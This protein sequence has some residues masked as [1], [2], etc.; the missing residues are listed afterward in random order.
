MQ[1][2]LKKKA[3][4]GP[5]PAEERYNRALHAANCAATGD[6]GS[7]IKAIAESNLNYQDLGHA[8]SAGA[9]HGH[10]DIVRYLLTKDAHHANFGDNLTDIY[11]HPPKRQLNY[12]RGKNAMSPLF[13]ACRNGHSDIAKLLLEN[14]LN[15]NVREES[16]TALIEAMK[17]GKLGIVKSLLDYG[18]TVTTQVDSTTALHQ[19]CI[20]PAIQDTEILELL[21]SKG[22]IMDLKNS[23]GYTPLHLAC[24]NLYVKKIK[25][26]LE[27]GAIV[28]VQDTRGDTPLLLLTSTDH[29]KT[30]KPQRPGCNQQKLVNAI[31]EQ[32]FDILFSYGADPNLKNL[33]GLSPWD[34]SEYRN[35]VAWN[36][37]GRIRKAVDKVEADNGRHDSTIGSLKNA[38]NKVHILSSLTQDLKVTAEAQAG[39]VAELRRDLVMV[40]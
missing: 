13:G 4:S 23:D 34:Y 32:G 3:I 7:L 18:A 30:I 6:L 2:A 24:K 27:K 1:S 10:D 39:T 16:S 35:Y 28:N 22:A 11:I 12:S 17:S 29:E 26:L 14:G 9:E 21:I 25:I 38:D 31:K 37:L 40:R 5:H 19:A 8:L 33:E 36:E 15:P 20:S